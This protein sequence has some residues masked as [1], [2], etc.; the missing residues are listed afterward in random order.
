MKFFLYIKL[1]KKKLKY[2]NF[3]EKLLKLRPKFWVERTNGW[4]GKETDERKEVKQM[5]G[6]KN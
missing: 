6:L 5:D 3:L 4:K 1:K 2:Y